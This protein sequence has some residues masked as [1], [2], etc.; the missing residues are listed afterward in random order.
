MIEKKYATGNSAEGHRLPG[1]TDTNISSIPLFPFRRRLAEECLVVTMADIRGTY[2]RQDLLRLADTYQPVT[3]RLGGQPFVLHLITEF[4][5][6]PRHLCRTGDEMIRVW[7][8]CP[9]CFRRVRKVYTYSIEP[10]SPMLAD[11]KCYHCH[12]LTYLSKNCSGNR[13]WHDFAM[14]MKRLLRR[15]E[16]L[17]L[18]K[19]PRSRAQLE[20]IDQAIWMLRERATVRKRSHRGIPHHARRKRPYRDLTLIQ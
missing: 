6:R 16:R 2:K 13:W 17:L 7:M 12:G 18:R 14:P 5:P 19:S 3:F 9:T 8:T 20:K 1:R 15:R 11:L 4:F 10:E